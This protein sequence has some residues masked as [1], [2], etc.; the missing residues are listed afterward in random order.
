VPRGGKDFASLEAMK[1]HGALLLV[2]A[3]CSRREETTTTTT[4]SAAIDGSVTPREAEG[5]DA[6]QRWNNA[7]AQRDLAQLAHVYGA[8]VTFAGVPMRRAQLLQVLGDRFLKDPSFTQSIDEVRLAAPLLV[9]LDRTFV[10]LGTTHVE[11]TTLDLAREDGGKL[12]VVGESDT[13]PHAV[14]DA[15]CVNLAMRVVLSTPRAREMLHAEG[16]GQ[17][18]VARVVA[19]PPRWPAWVVAIVDRTTP[20]EIAIGWFDVVP[21]TREVS[22][23][24]TGETLAPAEKLVDA[25]QTCAR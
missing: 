8:Y 3:T 21:A 22:E 1:W 17:P 14:N 9:Q 13:S 5:V 25:M 20:R 11:P 18:N 24:F 23:V 7:M 12:V 16:D 4:T 10:V 6:A 19:T 2:L 15:R